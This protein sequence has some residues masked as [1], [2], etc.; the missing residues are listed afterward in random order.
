MQIL[1]IIFLNEITNAS[2]IELTILDFDI[3]L[4]KD[5]LHK[6]YAT[7]DYRKRIL[8]FQFLNELELQWEGCGSNPTR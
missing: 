3:I 7:I 2:L 5:L 8:R 4:G 1:P 6:C